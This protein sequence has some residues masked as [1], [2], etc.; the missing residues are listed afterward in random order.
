MGG[1]DDPRWLGQLKWSQPHL[2]QRLDRKNIPPGAG[3]YAFTRD[4][5]LLARANALYIGKAD[6]ARQTLRSRLAAYLRRFA[7]YPAG[8]PA[9]HAGM[10]QLAEY[11]CKDKKS[12]YVR[13]CGVI[14]ARD[15]EGSLIALFDPSFNNKDE[16][17]LGFSDDELIPDDLLYTWRPHDN[18]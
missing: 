12:L 15:I 2:V 13:W 8:N 16:H 9:L 6:G 11:Y 5:G 17:R 1:T 10:E 7:V 14:V 3:L 18:S 4:N